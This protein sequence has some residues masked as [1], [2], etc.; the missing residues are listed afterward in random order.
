MFFARTTFLRKRSRRREGSEE[1]N[2]Q[3]LE[4][5]L[6]QDFSKTR[7]WKTKKRSSFKKIRKLNFGKLKR[8]SL[9]KIW[10]L[11]FE[12]LKRSSFEKFSKLE[13]GK[14]GNQARRNLGPCQVFNGRARMGGHEN[15]CQWKIWENE[16]GRLYV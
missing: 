1:P 2:F 10:K 7:I 9:G 16:K 3:I 11:E 5:Q 13:F 12:K 6:L 4:T 15:L 14:M 8:S